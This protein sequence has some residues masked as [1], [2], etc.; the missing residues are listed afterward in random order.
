MAP[1]P[2]TPEIFCN[3]VSVPWKKKE[4]TQ[5]LKNLNPKLKE[6]KYFKELSPVESKNSPMGSG[7]SKASLSKQTQPARCPTLSMSPPAWFKVA[8]TLTTVSGLLLAV[9]GQ[10]TTQRLTFTGPITAGE[11]DGVLKEKQRQRGTEKVGEEKKNRKRV[12]T[13]TP[14]SLKNVSPLLSNKGEKSS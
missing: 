11:V 8:T 3:L 5:N 2:S 12:R 6:N 7:Q 4:D 1:K 9:L 13:S 14:L 10:H